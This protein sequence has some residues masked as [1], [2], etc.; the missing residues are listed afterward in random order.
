MKSTKR[1]PNGVVK[2]TNHV[3]GGDEVTYVKAI[4]PKKTK[5]K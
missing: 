4:S 3:K 1:I 2:V 5:S